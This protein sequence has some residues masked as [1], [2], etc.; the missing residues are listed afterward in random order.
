MYKTDNARSERNNCSLGSSKVGSN[1]RARPFLSNWIS[2]Q[3]TFFQE[4]LD[5]R[6]RRLYL[7]AMFACLLIE[8]IR[9]DV[10]CP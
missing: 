8:S 10:K 4:L 3:Q 2:E 6:C 7:V 1:V 9:V 5:E